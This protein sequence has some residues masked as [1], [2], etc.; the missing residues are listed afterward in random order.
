MY[1]ANGDDNTVSVIH[2]ISQQPPDTTITS[3]VDDNGITL[4]KVHL[5]LHIVKINILNNLISFLLY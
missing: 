4:E 2:T 1:V 3:A 5:K